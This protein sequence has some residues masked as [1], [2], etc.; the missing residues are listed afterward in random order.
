ML[1]SGLC[2]FTKSQPCPKDGTP[3]MSRDSLLCLKLPIW[4]APPPLMSV[5]I[6]TYLLLCTVCKMIYLESPWTEKYN[7]KHLKIMI[8]TSKNVMPP[9]PYPPEQ[10]QNKVYPSSHLWQF[11][12]SPLPTH[13]DSA[14]KV[15][16]SQNIRPPPKDNEQFLNMLCIHIPI[17]NLLL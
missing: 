14:K 8:L 3:W 16:V 1:Q 11:C 4:Y 9:L 15:H 2:D 12:V 7:K 17:N 10:Q 13:L 6:I 5:I